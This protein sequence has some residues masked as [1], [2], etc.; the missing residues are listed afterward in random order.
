[1]TMM[2]MRIPSAWTGKDECNHEHESDRECDRWSN[3]GTKWLTLW[4][5]CRA[6]TVGLISLDLQWKRAIQSK[7]NTEK[8]ND[9]KNV[10]LV[11]ET[12]GRNG[13]VY[14]RCKMSVNDISNANANPV[15]MINHTMWLL[16]VL[17]K[18]ENM[19]TRTLISSGPSCTLIPWLL[20]KQCWSDAQDWVSLYIWQ[21]HYTQ[22]DY[23][24]YNRSWINT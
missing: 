21:H 8:I 20:D 19:F 12:I 22:A 18:E 5:Q 2:G 6:M 15:W 23:I 3:K 17:W 1:M 13:Q 4:P 24:P 11:R 16:P 14:D 9:I 10:Q 7:A